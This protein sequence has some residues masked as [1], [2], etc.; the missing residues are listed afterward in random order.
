MDLIIRGGK[1]VDGT[2][3]T[4][5][6]VG[7]G[8]LR[9]RFFPSRSVQ[10]LRLIDARASVCRRAVCVKDGL[11]AEVAE[12]GSSASGTREV[13]AS[14]KLVTPG[15]VDIRASPANCHCAPV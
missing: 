4:E 9:L 13:D 12:G 5:P 6:F 7:D 10:R 3:V 2:G 8:A 1:I 14:G 15:W 11:I